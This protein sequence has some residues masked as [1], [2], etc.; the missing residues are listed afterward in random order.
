MA[1]RCPGSLSPNEICF[2]RSGF[3]KMLAILSRKAPIQCSHHLQPYIYLQQTHRANKSDLERLE[4]HTSTRY[5]S[6]TGDRTTRIAHELDGPNL[7]E[8]F[9]E[10]GAAQERRRYTFRRVAES[11]SIPY[12]GRIKPLLPSESRQA[13]LCPVLQHGQQ[14][15]VLQGKR[16]RFP[17]CGPLTPP[18]GPWTVQRCLGS[19]Y[20][21][22]E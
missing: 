14:Y 3:S 16:N 17:R 22:G 18:T 2:R 20:Q 5:R 13:P 19:R 12:R 11:P 15:R 8:A 9:A 7:R 10:L 21:E 1:G 4:K 6:S